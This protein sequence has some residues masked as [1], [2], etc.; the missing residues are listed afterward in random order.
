M[1]RAQT[2]PSLHRGA[3]QRCPFV[4]GILDSRTCYLS[5]SSPKGFSWPRVRDCFPLSPALSAMT[6]TRSNN[7]VPR[8]KAKRNN[9]SYSTFEMEQTAGQK[10][11]GA[12]GARSSVPLEQ[13]LTIT[14]VRQT[15]THGC[16]LVLLQLTNFTVHQLCQRTTAGSGSS[17]AIRISLGAQQ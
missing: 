16:G 14:A 2:K 7:P 13:L 3:T 8:F 5:M 4:P 15:R 11:D 12:K 6:S 9:S 10:P 17:F 1:L